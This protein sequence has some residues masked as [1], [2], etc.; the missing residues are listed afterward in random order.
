MSLAVSRGLRPWLFTY[1]ALRLRRLSL[2]VSRGL[3][4]WL[5]TVAALRLRLGFSL[6]GCGFRVRGIGGGR[7]LALG[8]GHGTQNR[9]AECGEGAFENTLFG[10]G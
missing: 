10:D 7:F 2:A 6:V 8:P 1:A 4:P 3:R 5:L 9:F